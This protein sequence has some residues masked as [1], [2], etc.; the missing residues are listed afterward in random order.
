MSKTPVLLSIDSSKT[1]D[2]MLALTIGKAKEIVSHVQAS[3]QI[4][5]KLEQMLGE[6]K[7]QKEEITDI[8]VDTGPGSFTGLRVG[9]AI[10]QTLG[11]LLHVP[12]NGQRADF[13]IKITYGEDKWG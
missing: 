2:I 4:L 6:E 5:P 12:V 10:A 3:E 11:I 9:I 1:H 8:K 13:P 7:M